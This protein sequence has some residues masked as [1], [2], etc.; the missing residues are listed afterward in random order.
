LEGLV[1]YQL[2]EEG[3][4][5]PL[6]DQLKALSGKRDLT[7]PLIHLANKVR[8]GGN[9]AA[10]FNLE[11]EPDKEIAEI[12]LDLLDFFVEY[13]YAMKDKAARLE[14]RI[15]TPSTSPPPEPPINPV[16]IIPPA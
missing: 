4:K 14:G 3:I 16:G 12:M 11:K 2:G 1:S 13:F 8:M 5:E 10:H 7:E 6:A 15:S 9:F